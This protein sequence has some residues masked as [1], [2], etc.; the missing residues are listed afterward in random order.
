[1]SEWPC[2]I[3]CWLGLGLAGIAMTLLNRSIRT[4]NDE[5]F[6]RMRQDH[7]ETVAFYRE[8]LDNRNEHLSLLIRHMTNLEMFA[9][10]RNDKEEE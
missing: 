6:E 9:G 4:D 5:W 10:I 1:M 3:G 7:R 2:L 8:M